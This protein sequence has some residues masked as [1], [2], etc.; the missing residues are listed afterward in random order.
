MHAGTYNEQLRLTTSGS[1]GSVIT[2]SNNGSDVVTVQSPSSPVL[3]IGGKSY[4]TIDGINFTYNGSGSD[5]AVINSTNG[6]GNVNYVTV[7]NSII[8]VAG[9]NGEGFGSLRFY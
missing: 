5:P 1:S 7:N 3:D 8:T 2:L 4:W 9:G 6:A